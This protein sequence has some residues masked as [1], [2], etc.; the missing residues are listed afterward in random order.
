MPL[1]VGRVDGNDDAAGATA[2]PSFDAFGNDDA[3][4]AA[5]DAAT[6]APSTPAPLDVDIDLPDMSFMT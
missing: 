3:D 4:A 1:V 5:A 6:P 2:T